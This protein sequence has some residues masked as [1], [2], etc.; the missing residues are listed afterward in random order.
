MKKSLLA[1]SVFVILFCGC[2][3]NANVSE[4]TSPTPAVTASPSPTATVSPSPTIEL[5]PT[6]TVTPTPELSPLEKKYQYYDSTY[7]GYEGFSYTGDAKSLETSLSNESYYDNWYGYG[8]S[9]YNQIIEITEYTR[10]GK[11]YGIKCFAPTE[12]GIAIYYF[13]LD[14]PEAIYREETNSSMSGADYYE[15]VDSEG[16]PYANVTP[17]EVEASYMK[18]SYTPLTVDDVFIYPLE[19]A[20][21]KISDLIDMNSATDV[22][23]GSFHYDNT[24]DWYFEFDG[25]KTY[26]IGFM[27]SYERLGDSFTYYFECTYVDKNLDHNLKLRNYDLNPQ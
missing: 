17:E 23:T 18:P 2:G 8:E 26:Y 5:S 13:Y 10:N 14:D 7:D 16:N 12:C 27:I 3:T 4:S 15:M 24:E 11:E 22:L 20:K 25:D 9:N 1:L 21:E 19:F 6:P